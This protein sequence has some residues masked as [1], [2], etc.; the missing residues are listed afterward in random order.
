MQQGY[1]EAVSHAFAGSAIAMAAVAV[2]SLLYTDR[3]KARDVLGV[4]AS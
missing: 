3:E 1:A 2:V 4:S